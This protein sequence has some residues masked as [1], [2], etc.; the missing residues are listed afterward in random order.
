MGFLMYW[1]AHDCSTCER[2]GG[3]CGFEN[4]EFICFCRDRPRLKSCDAGNSSS[5]I[6][7]D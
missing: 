3:R 7:Y 5:N 4:N 2:S 6:V 1:T